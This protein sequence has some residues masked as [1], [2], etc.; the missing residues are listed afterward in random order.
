L[1]VWEE[2]G[3]CKIKSL[4]CRSLYIQEG[5]RIKLMLSLTQL[6]TGAAGKKEFSDT[7]FEIGKTLL[8]F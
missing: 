7:N 6:T 4:I 2:R 1:P 8:V 5:K 3:T